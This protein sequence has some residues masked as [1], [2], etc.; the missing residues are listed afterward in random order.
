MENNQIIELL[1]ALCEKFDVA[2]DWTE[3][4]IVPYAQE[5]TKKIINYELWTSIF[6][7]FIFL[8]FSFI[9]FFVAWR[10]TKTKGFNWNNENMITGAAIIFTILGVLSFF[11]GILMI[12]IQI[13]DII[14]CFTFPEKIIFNTIQNLM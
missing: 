3:E 4:N 13:F 10:L 8:I 2:A 14:T 6:L 7:I 9:A 5:L 11:V 12:P 1:N